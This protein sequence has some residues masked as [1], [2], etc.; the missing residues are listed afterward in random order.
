[1]TQESKQVNEKQKNLTWLNGILH[2][3]F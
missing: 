1:L 3:R 2:G